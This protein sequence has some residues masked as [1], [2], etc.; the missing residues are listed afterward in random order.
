M[1]P[2]AKTDADILYSLACYYLAD[3]RTAANHSHYEQG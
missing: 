1:E 2:V 3:N